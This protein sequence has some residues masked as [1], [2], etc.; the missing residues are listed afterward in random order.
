MLSP[1]NFW[2]PANFGAV[3]HEL[4]EFET[5][6]FVVL[7]VPY[8][9]TTTWRGGTRSG[10]AAIIEASMNMELFDRELGRE[11]CDAGMHTTDDIEPVMS[12][13][14][15]MAS[16]VESVIGE[17]LDA[18]KIP[19][20]LGGE[21]SLTLGGVRALAAR[22]EKISV[23]QIDAHTD[24][25]DEYADTKFGH[26]CVMRRCSEI[27][28]VSKIVQVGLRSTSREEHENIPANVIQFW[29]DDILSDFEN[30][31]PRILRE[32]EGTVYLTFDVD[33]CDPSWMP[34]TGTPEPG[35]LSFTQVRD[36][37]KAVCATKNVGALDCL[38][39]IGG[40]EASAF[41]VA[42][43]LYKTMGYLS[44]NH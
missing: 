6:R 19:V 23:L 36:L 3:S 29:A 30:Q 39:L 38:E 40:H 44:E 9:S 35:G 33:G 8:D 31:I 10:P 15:G 18:G 7:P 41:A 42:R 2:P 34:D 28:N 43:L 37:F 26:G 24:L 16:R 32:L 25:R 27:P 11:I 13:P 22:N 20:M 4:A 5:A 12:G 17:V 1:H 21:H 14:E